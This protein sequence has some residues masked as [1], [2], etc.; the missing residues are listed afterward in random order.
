MGRALFPLPQANL[1]ASVICKGSHG[2]P[3]CQSPSAPRRLTMPA[4]LEAKLM[5][6]RGKFLLVFLMTLLASNS[7]R[8]EVDQRPLRVTIVPAFPH[9]RW[10]DWLTGAD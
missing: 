8:A 1:L 9:L 5:S 10:P 6:V 4:N 3:F 7:V 2:R